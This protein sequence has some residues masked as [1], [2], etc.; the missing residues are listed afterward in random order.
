MSDP[1]KYFFFVKTVH[2]IISQTFSKIHSFATNWT[3][4]NK[5]KQLIH[6]MSPNLIFIITIRINIRIYTFFKTIFS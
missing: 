2:I 3:D 1:S 6:D 4:D 5:C